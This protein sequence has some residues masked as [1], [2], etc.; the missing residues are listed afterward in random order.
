MF[1]L[2]NGNNVK[3]VFAQFWE[4]PDSSGYSNYN[5]E[6]K[7]F[8]IKIYSNEDLEVNRMAVRYVLRA[9]FEFGVMHVQNIWD[10]LGNL[11]ENREHI[12]YDWLDEFVDEFTEKIAELTDACEDAVEHISH[13][14]ELAV[15]EA[16][17]HDVDDS[18]YND[19]NDSQPER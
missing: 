3:I 1:E 5:P 17:D 13:L 18:I 12:K 11:V 19:Q 4:T 2:A 16:F 10:W 14:T 7:Y 15:P 9:G 8:A 6:D